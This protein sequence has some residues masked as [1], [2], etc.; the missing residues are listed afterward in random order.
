MTI[1]RKIINE[2]LNKL[3]KFYVIV[4]VKLNGLKV[5]MEKLNSCQKIKFQKFIICTWRV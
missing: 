4:K 2:F 5:H 3:E 1:V